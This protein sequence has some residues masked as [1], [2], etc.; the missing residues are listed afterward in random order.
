[1]DLKSGGTPSKQNLDY[2]G[3]IVPWV[4][5]RDL[6]SFRLTDSTLK[7]TELG[8]DSGTRLVP[9]DTILILVRGMT[10]FKNV[11]VGITTRPMAFNQDIKA[12]L[13]KDGISPDFL[14]FTLVSSKERLRRYV[15]T[16]GH[17]TGRL[18]SEFLQALPI[19]VPPKKEQLLIATCLDTWDEVI[20]QTA[21]LIEV[22]QK[23]KKGLMQKLLTGERRFPGFTEQWNESRL[24]ELGSF[25][26]G[27]GISKP[28]VTSEGYSAVRYGELYTSHH[29]MVKRIRSFIS[30]ESKASSKRI[31]DGDIL[32][33]GSGET[34]E[35]I[36]K[37]AVFLG[38]EETYAG[39]DVIIFTPK[40]G[41]PL[42]LA[43]ALN[44]SSARKYLRTRGQGNSVVHI[45]KRDLECL[46]VPLPPLDEQKRIAQCLASVD[47][48]IDS[49]KETVRQ[50]TEQK[51]GLMQQLLTGKIR[52][53]V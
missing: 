14:A 48:E 17:G 24:G 28:E 3:G 46:R 53:K 42:Y 34:A 5:A 6:T 2:W 51:C 13:P 19:L 50:L 21:K 47:E 18:A 39:G 4:S 23:L 43:Y 9:Q 33:A 36:G 12:L 10:L 41:D 15:D 1:V 45:Y 27:A 20:Q 8:V 49:L 32:F 29:I 52:V 25:S 38:K 31:N 7:L 37:S 16:A 22:K 11:P 30:E 26:K 44:A 35:E 40:K